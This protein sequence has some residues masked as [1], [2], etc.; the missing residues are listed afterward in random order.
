MYKGQENLAPLPIPGSRA[1]DLYVRL[2][3]EI[4]KKF[5]NTCLHMGTLGDE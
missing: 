2:T 1:G 5:T 3:K 4:N